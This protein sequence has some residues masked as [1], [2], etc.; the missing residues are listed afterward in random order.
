MPEAAALW[1]T[2]EVHC[3][4]HILCA[5]LRKIIMTM[6]N[7]SKTSLTSKA[8][9]LVTHS[10][11]TLCNHMDCSPSGTSV[12]GIPR[13]EYWNGL[14]L[15]S[16][17][18]LPHPGTE[19]TSPVLAGRFFTTEPPGKTMGGFIYRYFCSIDCILICP[20]LSMSKYTW[21]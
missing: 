2:Q 15:P 11:L 9:V 21:K 7:L 12:H 19:F 16:P 1:A 4:S 17:G 5:L 8:K 14:P 10:Y 13:Q 20:C 3:N 18:D 6:N